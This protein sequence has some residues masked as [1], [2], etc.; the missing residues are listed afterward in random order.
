MKKMFQICAFCCLFCFQLIG[1]F[2]DDEVKSVSV[3]EGKSV[4]LNISVTEIKSITMIMWK[5]G[6]N[7]SLIAKISKFSKITVYDNRLKLDNQTGSLTIT[8][9]NTIDSGLYKAFIT[10]SSCKKTTHTFNVTVYDCTFCCHA[11]EAVTRLVISAVVGVAAVFFMVYDITSRK[12]E[13]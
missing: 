10:C 1:V 12:G 3:M 5:F 4:T 11:T 9:I 13:K 6:S 2:A 7:E 8:N